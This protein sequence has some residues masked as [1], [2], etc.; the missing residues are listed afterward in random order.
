[1][2]CSIA[3]KD[4]RAA[5]PMRLMAGGSLGRMATQGHIEAALKTSGG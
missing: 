4:G 3:G 5:P 2:P 1:M